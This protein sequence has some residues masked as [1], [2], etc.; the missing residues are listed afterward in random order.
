VSSA[1]NFL[2]GFYLNKGTGREE[3][4]RGGRGKKIKRKKSKEKDLKVN[5][6]FRQKGNEGL[7]TGQK[8]TKTSKG[9]ERNSVK[10]GRN[11]TRIKQRGRKWRGGRLGYEGEKGKE[12]GKGGRIT[13]GFW[14]KR[15]RR[16][17][18][19]N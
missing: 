3:L 15:G 14:K 18:P 11:Q 10:E 16:L 5:P 6:F 17:S 2:E 19:K 9:G 1:E 7:K 13:G 12:S 8:E 4:K